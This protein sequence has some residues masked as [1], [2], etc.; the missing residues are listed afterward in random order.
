MPS[1]PL[2]DLSQFDF[3][4]PLFDLEA[5]RAVNPQRY[6]MEQL[7]GIV[8]VDESQ[9]LIAGFK[10]LTTDEF[11]V[12]GHMPGFALMPGVVQCEA[13]AQLG[14]FY[15]RKYNLIGGDYLGFGGMNEVRFRKPIFPGARLDL[16]ARVTRVTGKRLAQFDFQG[17]VGGE[18]M[19][20]GQMLGVSVNRGQ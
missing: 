8:H 1:D 14:G 9:H 5:I 19:F 3:D 20:E 2:C 10:Q 18:L 4:R 15:A 11:W 13:A 7:T 17:W 12:R 6:E 16:V